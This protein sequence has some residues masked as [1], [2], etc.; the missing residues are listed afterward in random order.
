MKYLLTVEKK[1]HLKLL[2]AMKVS[3]VFIMFF[4]T[5]AW[6]YSFGQQATVTGKVTGE[7]D[8]LLSGVSVQVKGTTK[9]TTTNAQGVYSISVSNNDVLVF[10]Y[11][12]YEPQEIAA[13]NKTEINVSLVAGKTNLEQVVVIGYGTAN[14]R[15]LTGSIVKVQG[16]EIADKP[17]SNPVSSLQSKVP[18]LY[19]VNN[20]TPGK[21]P[22]IRIRGTV[23]LGQVHPLYV[24]DGIFNDN[25]DFLNPNDIE[26]IEVLKDP[27][28]LA[29]FGVKGAT[30][31]SA[32]TTKK[33]KAGTTVLNFNTTFG[34]KELVDKIQVT[35]AEE[36]KTLFDEERTNNG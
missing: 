28:S 19:V 7:A 18:G 24:V 12:G 17:N 11:V 27:S 36:F 23:S 8:K 14:K 13:A 3:V 21:Q 22:D 35:N 30:G 25:I 1:L 15:D 2:L 6:T 4:A 9:G 29:I 20:A 32:I 5:Q 10:S 26:S 31:V 33:A 16:K 34:F